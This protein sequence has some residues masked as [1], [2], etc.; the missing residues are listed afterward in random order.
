MKWY[1]FSANELEN[2]LQTNLSTGLTEK[3]AK[4][5]LNDYGPNELQQEERLSPII[6]FL[7]QFKDFM[8]LVLL[9]ATLISGILGEYMDAIAIML[10]VFVNGILGYV[11]ERKAERS[12]HA[13]KQL[14]SPKVQ[15]LRQ[16]EWNTILSKE[17][18][19]GD[20]IRFS[21]GDR[22]GADIRLIESK[23]LSVEESAL[24]GESIPSQK[25]AHT[26]LQGDQSLGDQENMCFMGTMVTSGRGVGIV[27]STGMNTEMGKIAHLLTSEEGL[28]TPLQKR[29][30]QLGKILILVA[31]ALTALVVVV[32]VLQGQDLYTMF[33][34]GVSLAVAAIP[35]GLPAIVTIALALGVQ[36][37]IRRR[38]I[39]RKLPSVETLG[40]A[41]VI[42]S[43]KT[44]TLTQN[45]MTVTE[46]WSGGKSWKVSGTGFDLTG[47]FTTNNQLIDVEQSPALKQLLT[48]GVLCNNASISRS[49]NDIQGDPTEVALLI[50]GLK[51]GLSKESLTQTYEIIEEFP[52]DSERKM[53]SV[54]VKTSDHQRYIVTKGAPDVILSRSERIL[55]NDRSSIMDDHRKRD[56][57]HTIENM[58][59]KALRT[60]AV[61][62]RALKNGEQVSTAFEAETNLTLIGLQG[63][64][65]PPRPEAIESI[66][67]CQQ[68]GIKTVMITGDHIV[69]AR[70][71]AQQ[72]N[73]LPDHGKVLEGNE[74]AAMSV[75]ELE[76]VVDEVYVFARVSPEHKLKI[77]KALQNNG[78]IVAMTGDGVND[79][80][81]IKA[82]NIG[83]S[84]GK[85]GTDVAREASSLILS[86]DNFA[87]IRSAIEEG[88]NIYENIRK[89][90]RYLLA[91]N[92][93]EILVMLFAMLMSL[94]LPLVP[95]QILWVN[96]VTDGLPA[97]A[98]GIDSAEEDVMKRSP[99]GTTEGVFS[100]GLGWKIISRGFLIGV[101]TIIAF[102]IA[103]YENPENLVRA[104]T[105][106]FSTL[107][108]AQL[109]HVFDCRS[110]KSVFHRNP[111]GNIYLVLAVLS[112]IALLIV[113]IYYPPLQP[114]FHTI[115]LNV[116]E[117]MLVIGM[118]GLPTFA[119]AGSHIF[120][121]TK[122][123]K[124]KFT[125]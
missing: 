22:I 21:A 40:C 124:Y 96:L 44:G 118:A 51:A 70:A 48:F 72:L 54:L 97:M 27:V 47:D 17:V 9:V 79:A 68:A 37:M 31:L 105:I 14:S 87:T 36:K 66:Q 69:T 6:V 103:Y 10:I 82:A 76:S 120:N 28:Q 80:P 106:A 74:L 20:M 86:D 23:S 41:T 3:Q 67:D 49:T 114:I 5:R 65:D 71:I 34:A 62:Y 90:I 16:G 43:D 12:L 59:N 53:M 29:L 64:I 58:G 81:A 25:N 115:S 60:I 125:K 46:M 33:L 77:V 13:L 78:H 55:W 52:F 4:K 83:I 35:E 100:R 109:I 26:S 39:V 8:V 110:E 123:A 95:I 7:S 122:Q 2:E 50:A 42:C 119:L 32:G 104:Q 57:H 113:V 99:R 85:S 75:E 117:W 61:G 94:P 24:T 1:T 15:V 84:M 73:M 93:G 98:L 112:S 18:V 116:R 102:A 108:M 45:K 30:E 88:R 107:V 19:P 111:F 101:V 91:S 92:V 121:Q 38:A 11:Q 89:F 63:M 56:V